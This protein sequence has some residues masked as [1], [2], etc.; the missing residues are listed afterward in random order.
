[1]LKPENIINYRNAAFAIHYL[2]NLDQNSLNEKSL[3]IGITNFIDIAKRESKDQT[4]FISSD[5]LIKNTISLTHALTE[6]AQKGLI[7][8]LITFRKY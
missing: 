5:D 8:F 2:L 4:T 7:E 6:E 3:K 1:M